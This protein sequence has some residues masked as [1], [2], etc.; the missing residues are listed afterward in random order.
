MSEKIKDK[1]QKPI[2]DFIKKKEQQVAESLCEDEPDSG[3]GDI[4]SKSYLFILYFHSYILPKELKRA[5][6][7]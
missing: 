5:N 6:A 2:T 1:K 3:N 7:N 4:F